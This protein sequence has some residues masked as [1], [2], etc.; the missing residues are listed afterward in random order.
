MY[1][2]TNSG[3]QRYMAL[4]QRLLI[5][6]VVILANLCSFCNGFGCCGNNYKK[7]YRRGGGV[8]R[9]SYAIQRMYGGDATRYNTGYNTRL[10]QPIH[11][12]IITIDDLI[13]RHCDAN[14]CHLEN[15]NINHL[16]TAQFNEGI[17]SIH[18]NNNHI[19][20]LKYAKLPHSLE[21]LYLDGNNI[22]FTNDI[23]ISEGHVL[24]LSHMTNLRIL[25]LERNQIR[26]LKYVHLPHN[27][28]FLS[29]DGNNFENVFDVG[30]L[31]YL[32]SLEYLF[33]NK[34][35][36]SKI[37]G[38]L[39]EILPDSISSLGFNDDGMKS[40]DVL[41]PETLQELDLRN[42]PLQKAVIQNLESCQTLKIKV[43]NTNSQ[44]D[45]LLDSQT[46][47]LPKLIWNAEVEKKCEICCEK[48]QKGDVVLTLP[49]LHQFHCSCVASW[50][51]KHETCPECRHNINVVE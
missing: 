38:D 39:R 12:R 49:C 40:I 29:L 27:L 41:V 1:V 9:S 37:E 43:E 8:P 44:H 22:D 7:P 48:F 46:D 45:K 19:K 36:I 33:L 16:D 13:R 34:N 24:D 20:Q 32:T 14:V 31:K 21:E 35:K 4:I 5:G 26:S 42:N 47:R 30:D 17:T 18:L 2:R 10:P 15:K 25:S 51:K 6:I 11:K 23:N 3:I 50:L 28:Q